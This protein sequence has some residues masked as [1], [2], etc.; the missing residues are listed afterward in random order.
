MRI[1]QKRSGILRV[2]IGRYWNKKESRKS[3][4]YRRISLGKDPHRSSFLLGLSWF[5][6][7]FIRDHAKLAKPLTALLR[8]EEGRGRISKNA[9]NRT[10]IYLYVNAR[11]AFNKLKQTLASEEVMLAYPDYSKEFQLTT[12]ASDY[13]IGAVLAREDKPIMFIS[14]TLSKAE[15]S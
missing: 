6:R 14:R 15:E 9:S 2:F 8:G 7:R 11:E 1:L 13:A 3:Q 4:G 10:L 5:Y 12:D